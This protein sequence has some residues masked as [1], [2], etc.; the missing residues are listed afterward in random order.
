VSEY[1]L[2]FDLTGSARHPTAVAVLD[3]GRRLVDLG[4][5]GSD[6]E[7]L[8]IVERYAA[9]WV[10]IDAP[11]GLPRGLHCLER[12]CPCAPEPDHAFRACELALRRL[13]IACFYT[14]KGSII[15]PM[16]YRAVRLRQRFEELGV[17]VLEVF[18]YA[19][20]VTLW[21]RSAVRRMGK[22]TTAAGLLQLRLAL[23]GELPNVDWGAWTWSHDRCDALLCAYTVA[24]SRGGAAEALGDPD[25]GQIVLPRREVVPKR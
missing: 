8:G 14:V 17:P 10:G 19:V 5:L 3:E 18:P 20:K 9:A 15:A 2:G 12:S 22:K 13:G 7:L 24:L 23:E 25:E 21:G 1:Y 6:A 11:L 4:E 16:V